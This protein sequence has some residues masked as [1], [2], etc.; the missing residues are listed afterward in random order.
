MEKSA[1][2][3]DSFTIGVT[4]NQRVEFTPKKTAYIEFDHQNQQ[5]QHYSWSNMRALAASIQ[6]WLLSL[7]VN[8]G[9]RIAL[10]IPNGT[11]WVAIDQ[12]AAGL[13]IITVPL[14]PN[15]REDN[16]QYILEKTDCRIL[17]ID[18]QEQYTYSKDF[19]QEIE[20]LKRIVSITAITG[21]EM[22]S[23]Q[24]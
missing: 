1:Y 13:G 14:Y 22:R 4:F 3:D 23:C 5:W 6:A 8:R 18:S 12:A 9:E 7:N 19:I 20:S 15:D 24:K 16:V 17:F 10:M 21:V 11:L 2:S